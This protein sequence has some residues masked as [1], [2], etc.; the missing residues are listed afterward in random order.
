[1][2]TN[3]E[4]IQA[5]VDLGYLKREA[6]FLCTAALNSG[7]FLRRQYLQFLGA[8]PGY[9]DDLLIGKVINL[10]HGRVV[11]LRQTQLCHLCSRPFY[12]AIGEPDNRNRRM[13]SALSM[14]T[15]LMALDY[16]ISSPGHEY[17][18]TEEQKVDFF[19]RQLG[20]ATDRLPVK[21][22]Q[23][24]H[25]DSTTDRYFV[26]K[27]PIRIV[28]ESPPAHPV[29][30]FCYIDEGSVATPGFETWLGQYARLFS[31][32]GRFRVVYVAT[33]ETRFVQAGK[34][35]RTFAKSV[36]GM[37]T[38]AHGSLND[39]LL[40]YFQLEDLFRAG[41]FQKLDAA[42]LDD[43]RRLRREFGDKR[44]ERLFEAWRQGGPSAVIRILDEDTAV[45]P[46]REALFETC[47]IPWCYS[48]LFNREVEKS[49]R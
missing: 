8:K 28:R 12:A 18:A 9:A 26:D 49:G 24:R 41:D 22:Y 14:Q 35:F 46:P 7:F 33:K 10:G 27:F 34:L 6:E 20:I 2:M 21:T 44:T 29:V 30:S 25:Q 11:T 42:K 17:L 32:L 3:E 31:I 45:L 19:N 36:P 13:R 43:L 47:R 23:S 39:R 37:N 38:G 1:M 4:R 16:V 40:R 5:L 48:F 15:K